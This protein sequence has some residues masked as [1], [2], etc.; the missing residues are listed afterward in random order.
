MGELGW[1]SS[2]GDLQDR[3][4]LSCKSLPSLDCSSQEQGRR[5]SDFKPPVPTW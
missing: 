3:P 4:V 1:S 5:L 2:E